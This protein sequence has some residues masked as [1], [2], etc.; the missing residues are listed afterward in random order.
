MPAVVSGPPGQVPS[1]Q[2]AVRRCQIAVIPSPGRQQPGIPADAIAHAAC[3]QIDGYLPF[4]QQ[5]LL[6]RISQQ[7]FHLRTGPGAMIAFRAEDEVFT[8][9]CRENPGPLP[10][11]REFLHG[12]EASQRVEN[13]E[14]VIGIPVAGNEDAPVRQDLGR[15]QCPFPVQDAESPCAVRGGIVDLHTPALSEAESLGTAA[16]DHDGPVLQRNRKSVIVRVVHRHF[17]PGSVFIVFER[18]QRLESICMS[19]DNHRLFTRH[20]RVVLA[21]GLVQPAHALNAQ[22]SPLRAVRLDGMMLPGIPGRTS[23]QQGGRKYGQCTF[24]PV[25]IARISNRINSLCYSR[26]GRMA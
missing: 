24:H 19:A 12:G 9:L 1:R 16:A 21:P 5:G 20:Q 18:F 8:F 26:T 13:G 15:R 22:G 4:L 25:K 11:G 2:W 7:P 17:V 10:S 14:G 23:R 3:P 6:K